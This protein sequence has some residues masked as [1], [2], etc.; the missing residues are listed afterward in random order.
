MSAEWCH[1]SSIEQQ[2]EFLKKSSL[3][4]YD[5]KKKKRLSSH[6]GILE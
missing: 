5:S 1:K 6:L 2:N 4:H 3:E